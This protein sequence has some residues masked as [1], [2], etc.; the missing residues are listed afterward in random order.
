MKSKIC[1]LIIVLI[2]GVIENVNAQQLE[3]SLLSSAG[4]I[5]SSGNI[6]GSW[7]TGELIVLRFSSPDITLTQGFQQYF[8]NNNC[9]GDLDNNG[10]IN[11]NDLLL[12]LAAYGCSL[13]CTAD[14]T[15]DDLV[16]TSDLLLFLTV[17][18]T[19]CP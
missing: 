2:V 1:L 16:T 17:F 13:N 6:Q 9:L 12:L 5:T 14:L 7:T 10:L 8:I 15:G 4:S 18:G 11:T 19:I 3:R